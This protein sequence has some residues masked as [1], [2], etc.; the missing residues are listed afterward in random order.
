MED[1]QKPVHTVQDMRK[2]RIYIAVLVVFIAISALIAL[3]VKFDY[4]HDHEGIFI[5]KGQNGAW[6]KIGDD[7]FPE[8][9][10]LLLWGRSLNR[11]KSVDS[12]GACGPS[13]KPCTNY[14]WN[15][16][17]GRGFI[18]TTYPDG[19]KLVFNLGRFLDSDKLP[20]SGLFMGGGLPPGDPD[21]KLFDKNETGMAYY[22]GSRYYHIWC[23]VNEGLI[24]AAN[25]AIYPSRWEFI[26]SKVLESSSNDV[27]IVS[28]HRVLINNVPVTIERFL[29]YQNGDTFVTLVTNIKNIGSSPTLFSYLYGDEPWVGDYGSSAGNVGWL[30]GRVVLTEMEIDARRYT[31]AGMF[32]YGNP[33]AGENH[34]FYTGKANFIEWRP[35]SRP[36][37]A[38]FSNGFGKIAPAEQK[39]PLSSPDNRVIVLQWGA[40]TLNPGQTFSFTINVGMANNDPK[41]GL[42]VKPDTHLY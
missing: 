17:S 25:I 41:T 35:E 5:F 42:P 18:K 7:L 6:L 10:Q 4:H 40:R 37:L 24:D 15:T 1:W 38:Y 39:V 16:T 30:D 12:N 23:N 36:D 11:L 14:E 9:S 19:R 31:Y 26:S 21:F 13:N 28:K 29:F 22:D 2:R 32:D 34:E 27:T 20:V 8:E 33:L 3:K